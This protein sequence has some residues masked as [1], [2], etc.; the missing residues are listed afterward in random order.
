MTGDTEIASPDDPLLRVELQ[1][2]FES[3]NEV[4]RKVFIFRAKGYTIKEIS[5]YLGISPTRVRQRLARIKR[6]VEEYVG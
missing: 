4:D 5:K 3:L 2:L 1:E 6:K